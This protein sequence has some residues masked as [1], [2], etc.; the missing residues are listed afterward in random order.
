MQRDF[1]NDLK[2][3]ADLVGN[4]ARQENTNSIVANLAQR[5]ITTEERLNSLITVVER[6]INGHS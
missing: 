1:M 6:H 4:L 3:L 2:M 5:Q